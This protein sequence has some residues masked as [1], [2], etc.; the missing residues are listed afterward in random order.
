MS[1][2]TGRRLRAVTPRDTQARGDGQ[3]RQRDDRPR[4]V[5]RSRSC[6]C[7]TRSRSR[8]SMRAVHQANRRRQ[9]RLHLLQA[10]EPLVRRRPVRAL[11]LQHREGRVRPPRRT[12]RTAPCSSSK[13]FTVSPMKARSESGRELQHV[14]RRRDGPVEALG[15]QVREVEPRQANQRPPGLD[16]VLVA[17]PLGVPR[18]VLLER[19][20]GRRRLRERE[21]ALAHQ[22]NL[23]LVPVQLRDAEERHRAEGDEHDGVA[24][25]D[26][27]REGEPHEVGSIDQKAETPL[28]GG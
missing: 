21:V 17:E 2:R 11:P 8:A 7:C 20:D 4:P 1:V 3:H 16:A 5:R 22:T 14:A 25:E 9:R 6:A 15:H 23:E 10:I 12:P 27:S 18:L 19:L 28:C 24:D 13:R 26:P